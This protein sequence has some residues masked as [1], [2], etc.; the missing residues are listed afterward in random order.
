LRKCFKV[1]KFDWQSGF[2]DLLFVNPD[3]KAAYSTIPVLATTACSK[4]RNTSNKCIYCTPDHMA[5]ATT[6]RFQ[7]LSNFNIPAQLVQESPE[8]FVQFG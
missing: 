7:F 4:I 3:I 2:G 6:T 8:K 1:G 5:A